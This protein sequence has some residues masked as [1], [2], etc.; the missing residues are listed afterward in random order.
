LFRITSLTTLAQVDVDIISTF[1]MPVVPA[2]DS[3]YAYWIARANVG[4]D[5]FYFARVEFTTSATAI[6]SIRKK[7]PTETVLGTYDTTLT[8]VAGQSYK[9]RFR[10]VGP[11]LQAKYWLASDMEPP[12]WQ[13]SFQ[14]SDIAS[15]GTIGLRSFTSAANT[16]VLPAVFTWDD[17]ELL[18][19]QTMTVIRSINGIVKTHASGEA[20][21]LAAPSYT[22]L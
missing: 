20:V 12:A 16:N 11:S 6:L 7:L 19:P 17:Y 2:G 5:A 3:L 15:A 10:V 1:T 4:A 22:A 14:D 21:L 8:H 18:N 13:L 9:V